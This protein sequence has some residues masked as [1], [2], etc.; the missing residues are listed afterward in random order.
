M[1]DRILVPGIPVRASV[2]CTEDERQVPQT[3][4]IDLELRCDLARAAESDSIA[5]AIDYVHVRNE[6]ERVSSER[7]YALI[8]TI[9]ERIASTLL[10]SFPVGEALVRVRKPSALDSFG[11]RWA[12]VEIV[13]SRNG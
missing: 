3:I 13:R 8:E 7:P 6:V 4:F 10:E 1:R 5:D 12:G 11:V 2:G 9:A